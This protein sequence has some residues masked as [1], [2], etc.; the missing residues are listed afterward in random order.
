MSVAARFE[1]DV[2]DAAKDAEGMTTLRKL[3]IT[4]IQDFTEATAE[5]LNVEHIPGVMIT[6]VRR[7]SIAGAE[8]LQRGMIIT[9]VMSEP[10]ADIEELVDAIAR[11]DVAEG[12]R[13]SIKTWDTTADAYLSLYVILQ[14][15]EE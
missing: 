2:E 5:H 7:N 11:H 14:L 3:G 13:V 12:V 10:V 1:P 8:R 6:S 4:G 9:H 15:T